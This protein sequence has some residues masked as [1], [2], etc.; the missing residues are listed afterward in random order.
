MTEQSCFVNGWVFCKMLDLIII[1]TD[2]ILNKSYTCAV[3]LDSIPLSIC[4][5]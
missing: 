2:I 5:K 4:S 1:S 3:C